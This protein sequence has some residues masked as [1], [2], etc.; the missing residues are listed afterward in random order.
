MLCFFGIIVNLIILVFIFKNCCGGLMLDK[1]LIINFVG[2][3]LIVC[4]ISFLLYMKVINGGLSLV[5]NGVCLV[6]FFI[7]FMSFVVNIM[8][9]VI[10]SIDCYD[11]ICC[12]LFCEIII[13]KI[14]YYF[15]FIWLFVVC[16]VVV[17][18]SGYVL[19]V[20]WSEYV[21]FSFGWEIFLG[22]VIGKL[23]MFVIV[24]LWIFFFLVIMFYRFY[25]IVKYV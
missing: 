19:I 24:M 21:C 14:V 6:R 23:V 9:L 16:I 8:I 3:D 15:V 5:D 13:R 25:V 2:V 12:V 22:V 7:M 10:I 11:V 18:G 4:L 17:G 20:V 1:L